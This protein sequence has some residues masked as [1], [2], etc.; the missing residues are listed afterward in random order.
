MMENN[1]KKMRVWWMPQVGANATFYIPVNSV[2]Q[3]RFVMDVLAYYDCFQWNH[4]IKPDF[5]NCG[6]LQVYDEDEGEWNDWYYDDG[7]NYFDDVDE[8]L[9]NSEHREELL[10]VCKQMASQVH[11]D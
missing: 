1:N 3:A 9:E 2:E 10:E 5:C 11:F 7:E 8:Y 6:G 4:N